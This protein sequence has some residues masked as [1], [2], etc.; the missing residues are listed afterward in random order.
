MSEE[1]D[2]FEQ[3][4]SKALQRVDAPPNL[5]KFLTLAAEAEAEKNKPWRERKHRWVFVMPRMPVWAGSAL[6]AV[7][8]VGAFVG[9]HIHV[10]HQREAVARQQF[11]TA[12]QITNR[13]LEHARE[14]V[15]RAGVSLD[16]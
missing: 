2:D 15:E 11:E 16:Q 12:T 13:A 4:L 10:R 7:L 6:A 3:K 14:Q 8:V 9:G 1:M 5:V